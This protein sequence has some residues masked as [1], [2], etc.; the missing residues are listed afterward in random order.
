M[1]DPLEA[2]V[3]DLLRALIRNS[4]VNDGSLE[5]GQEVRNAEVLRSYLEGPGLDIATF[6]PA[7]GRTSLVVRIEGRPGPPAP[8]LLLM[9]HTDVVPANPDR[10]RRD[11]F[12]AELVDGEV[13][14]RGAIDM[15]NLTASMA[16]AIRCLARS[17]FTPRGGLVYLA[18]ADEE[19]LGTQGAKWLLEHVPEVVSADY[20]ITESG[21][22][23]M[24]TRAGL[25][26]PVMVA[27][28]GTFWCTLSIRGVSGHASQPLRT[29]NALIKAAEVVRR[30]AGY[31]PLPQIHDVWRRF[32]VEMGFGPELAGPLLDPDRIWDFCKHLPDVG[33][34]RQAHSCTHTTLAPTV[35]EGGT[36]TNVIP[37][38][39][40]LQVDIRTLPGQTTGEIMALL[41]DLL[42]DLRG[43]IDISVEDDSPSS[44]SPLDTP[45]WDALQRV[46][47]RFHPG[48]RLI[49]FLTAGATDAR[50]FRQRGIPAYG[51]GLFSRRM[52]FSQFVSMFHGDD[53]RVDTESL[54]LSTQLWEAL[55]R[56]VVG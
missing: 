21:G 39:V 26:L 12:A 53:E 4:C 38:Q 40:K 11:P 45:L 22:I 36:K 18:V 30:I 35:I 23:P 13:W 42:G 16:V 43:D 52:S 27:E 29:G 33:L 2:E 10:W 46:A 56:D 24:E 8:T 48:A 49:P 28:K 31:R 5:S 15:L 50:F 44:A 1:L 7:A 34:A 37:D 55:A 54:R 9:G 47:G 25:R 32:V 19:A 17:G 51:F 6:E 3:T 14:G 20:V 41:D